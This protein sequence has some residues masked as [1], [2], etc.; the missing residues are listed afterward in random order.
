VNKR[1]LLAAL[2]GLVLSTF[3]MSPAFAMS[4]PVFLEGPGSGSVA[5]GTVRIKVEAKPE[6]L[7][8]IGL[9]QVS[10]RVTASGPG[11]TATIGDR[12]GSVFED[13]WN[14]D[15]LALNGVY[16]LKATASSSN[17]ASKTSTVSGIKVNNPPAPPTGVKAVLKEGVPV[18]SWNANP[19]ADITGYKLLRSADGGSFAQV[20]GGAAT[21]AS[22]T[23]APH[24]KPL[25]YRVVAVRKSPVSAGV[26]STSAGTSAL[27]VPAPPPPAADPGAPGGPPPDP[28]KPVIPG[29]N[30]VTGKE[31]PKAGLV[32]NKGF[33]KAIA[34]IV[35]SAPAGTAFD[36]TL[37]YSG[38]PPEQFEAASGGDPSVL[39]AG[40]A[41]SSGPTVTNPFKFII[42]GILL[43]VAAFFMWRASRKL[44]VGTRPQDQIAPTRVNFP[45]FRVNRG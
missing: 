43:M 1:R 29:T 20:Y 3:W 28:S 33:G 40:A 13:S 45:T 16:E 42:G 17:S 41:D 6:S 7:L 4:A 10:I 2:T 8:G 31:T 27:T 32:P 30:I 19:E 26:E 21:S 37:P 38:V 5:D 25:T 14:V 22:D 11:G 23:N 34:P 39:D 12:P 35:K 9:E 24:S 18:V 44:L 36:E 15:A